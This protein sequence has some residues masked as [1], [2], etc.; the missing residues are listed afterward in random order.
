MVVAERAVT[1]DGHP[2]IGL[3]GQIAFHAESHVDKRRIRRINLH[4]FDATNLL[5]AGVV[6][7]GAGFQP[8]GIGKFGMKR[9][10]GALKSASDAEDREDQQRGGDQHEESNKGLLAFFC[11][12]Y[13]L[14]P[15]DGDPCLGCCSVNICR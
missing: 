2:A 12:I 5:A 8:R 1:H 4:F 7:G 3:H 15:G 10:R 9:L 6:D 11:H 14:F 13:L